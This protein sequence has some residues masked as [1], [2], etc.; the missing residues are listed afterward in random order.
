V[1]LAAFVVLVA[2]WL[3]FPSIYRFWNDYLVTQKHSARAGKVLNMLSEANSAYQY[4][5]K[6]IRGRLFVMYVLSMLA[7]GWNCWASTP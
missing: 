1:L 4:L 7:W 3:A 5:R 2:V 6:L